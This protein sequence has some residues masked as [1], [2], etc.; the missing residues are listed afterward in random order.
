MWRHSHRFGLVAKQ[1]T[2]EPTNNVSNALH[3]LIHRS[4]SLGHGNF[5][6]PLSFSGCGFLF[7]PLEMKRFLDEVGSP[8]IG[9]YFDPGNMAV[10]Q[11]PQHWVRIT[12]P[13][14][15]R[16]HMKDWQGRALNGAW[17]PLL[18]GGVDFPAVMAE[19]RKIGYEEPLISEV[20][21]S[22]ASLEDTAVAIRKI[23]AM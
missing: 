2:K 22:L 6:L 21:P 10:Y 3:C 23:M 14:I 4:T 12:G 18:E 8:Q 1:S 17:H 20:S 13:H 19:L 5:I 7:S 16:V 9:F 11:F 15:K